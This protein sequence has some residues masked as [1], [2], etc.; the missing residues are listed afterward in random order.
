MGL[1]FSILWQGEW[2]C[3]IFI[4]KAQLGLRFFS[5]RTQ[6]RFCLICE[7]GWCGQNQ[8]LQVITTTQFLLTCFNQG[9]AQMDQL[10]GSY[11]LIFLSSRML[12]IVWLM[13]VQYPFLLMLG[14][15]SWEKKFLLLIAN[16]VLSLNSVLMGYFCQV[17]QFQYFQLVYM[18][19]TYLTSFR[20]DIEVH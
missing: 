9:M 11:L 15:I 17:S 1:N 16:M 7:R 2:Q 10:R 6:K 8:K 4:L 20:N 18:Q 5:F 3:D 19:V 13:A 14:Y 12:L